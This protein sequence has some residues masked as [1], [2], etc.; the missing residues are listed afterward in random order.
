MSCLAVCV[1]V[2]VF[3]ICCT[4]VSDL[5]LFLPSPLTFCKSFFNLSYHLTCLICDLF[6]F[7]EYELKFHTK[8]VQVIRRYNVRCSIV[9]WEVALHFLCY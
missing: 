1:E 9:L 7:S 5:M 4:S 2:T 3:A 8:M 6:I